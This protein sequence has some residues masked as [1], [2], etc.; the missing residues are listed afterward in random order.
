M[1]SVIP[2]KVLDEPTAFAEA[3]S[4]YEKNALNP[5]NYDE[6]T[7]WLSEQ[8]VNYDNFLKLTTQP[9]NNPFGI[10]GNKEAMKRLELQKPRR[11]PTSNN[12]FMNV[13]ISDYNMPQRFSK[14]EPTCGPK[15]QKTFYEKLLQ[16]PDDALWERKASERQFYTMPNTSVPDERDKFAQWLFG[17]NYVGKTGSIYD[18]YGYPYTPDSLVNTG[19][20]ASSPQN[21]GQVDNNY[22]L[23]ITPGASPW[24]NN[25][26]YGGSFGGVPGGIPFHNLTVGQG[27]ANYLNPMPLMPQWPSPVPVI[28]QGTV[29]SGLHVPPPAVPHAY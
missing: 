8:Q 14:A 15:C 6:Y 23:P 19:V 27:D 24:V 1:Y 9:Q 17:N 21:A 2:N 3:V 20:N 4:N 26:N 7:N 28:S 10:T 13:M 11:E 16:S 22:G 12:P 18:R 29:P 25:V 5:A